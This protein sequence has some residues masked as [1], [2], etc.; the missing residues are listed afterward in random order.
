MTGVCGGVG[1]GG[2][3]AVDA[4]ADELAR[5]GD[6]VEHR[7]VDGDAALSLV[8]HRD[9]AQ[10]VEA[11]DGTLLWCW[12]Q[13]YGHGPGYRPRTE[14]HPD[15]SAAEF[16][17]AVY[18]RHGFDTV[19]TLNGEY[20]LLAC[21][22]DGEQLQIVTD[23][24]GTHPVYWTRTADGDVV[25]CSSLQV[26]AAHP[27]VTVRFDRA[28][29]YEYFAFR[30]TF[31]LRTALEGVSM[32]HPGAITTVD[33]T[34]GSVETDVYWRPRHEPWT[35][36]RGAARRDYVGRFRGAVADREACAR[37]ERRT[38][39]TTDRRSG[40]TTARRTGPAI[41]RGIENT[42]SSTG[43]PRSGVLLSGGNDSRAIVAAMDEPP[44]GFHIT[45]DETA[46]ETQVAQRVLEA[47]GAPARILHRDED[48]LFDV[49][50]SSPAL[51]DFTSWFNQAHAYAFADE[52]RSDCDLLYTGLYGDVYSGGTLPTHSLPTPL[53]RLPIPVLD[54]PSSVEE[55]VELYLDGTFDK[56]SGRLPAYCTPPPTARDLLTN[57]ITRLDDDDRSTATG[58]RSQGELRHHGVQYHDLTDLLFAA[59]YPVTN[60]HS[61]LFYSSLCQTMPTA[62]P[63]FDYRLLD[64]LLAQPLGRLLRTEV[65]NDVLRTCSPALASIPHAARGV[66]ARQPVPIQYASH[67]L[68][69]ARRR[70]R[71]H[72]RP[73][74]TSSV[75]FT[76]DH[77]ELLRS[78]PVVREHVRRHQDLI[79][80]YDWLDL[81]GIQETYDE[82]CRGEH[83]RSELFCLLTFLNMPIHEHVEPDGPRLSAATTE[84]P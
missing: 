65:Q 15:S 6:E 33:V 53:G 67:R 83:R 82:H 48:A 72:L 62:N 28:G 19:A 1:V 32:V 23:R 3:R 41:E 4:L 24:L 56:H 58:D 80:R 52:L 69:G 46:V 17:R 81:D 59:I 9:A 77:D 26:L 60:R 44:V 29:L 21:S 39:S 45:H 50:E 38:E 10:P 40:R 84:G 2:R 37:A 13:I 74:V 57:E 70:L 66:S 5:F 25:F 35:A 8:S 7:A 79:D 27:D 49:L 64:W 73:S 22:P 51:C 61:F 55:Y 18:D 30:R 71:S 54:A 31:G 36:S 78:R 11:A 12:G 16:C 68:Q 20:A 75:G 76:A 47:A 43:A 42:T 34:D 63:H 14:T